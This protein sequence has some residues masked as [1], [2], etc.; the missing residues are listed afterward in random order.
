MVTGR[1]FSSSRDENGVYY[2]IRPPSTSSQDLLCTGTIAIE[3]PRYLYDMVYAN[4]HAGT[5]GTTRLS[6]WDVGDEE[7]LLAPEEIAA[8]V[9]LPPSLFKSCRHSIC[10][11]PD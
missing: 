10:R 11:R 4:T 5:L 3:L 9:F 7:K 8:T 1:G 2:W 6:A